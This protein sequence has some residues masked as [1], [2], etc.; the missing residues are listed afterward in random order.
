MS[1]LEDRFIEDKEG[2]TEDFVTVDQRDTLKMQTTNELDNDHRNLKIIA[3][4]AM[5]FKLNDSNL[6]QTITETGEG[7]SCNKPTASVFMV[8]FPKAETVKPT[9]SDSNQE[10]WSRWT[11]GSKPTLTE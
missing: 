6:N 5:P 3:E 2:I 8:N 11:F 1:S 7:S 9:Q 4:E 10:V